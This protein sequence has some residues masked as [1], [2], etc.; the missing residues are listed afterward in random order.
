MV[1]MKQRM[2]SLMTMKNDALILQI[3]H[4]SDLI[5]IFGVGGRLFGVRIWERE[6]EWISGSAR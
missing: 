5:M 4:L 6:K 1:R 2:T 3:V